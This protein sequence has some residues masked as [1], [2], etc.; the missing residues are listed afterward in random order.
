MP[1]KRHGAQTRKQWL[2]MRLVL[3]RDKAGAFDVER[4][5]RRVSI[6]L[7]PPDWWRE[8]IANTMA[9]AERDDDIEIDIE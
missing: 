1:S 9:Q 5:L 4:L 6:E 8:S 7:L 3:A 2:R